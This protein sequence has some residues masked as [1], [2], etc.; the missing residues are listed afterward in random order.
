MEGFFQPAEGMREAGEL[1]RSATRDIFERRGVLSPSRILLRNYPVPHPITA[2]NAGARRAGDSLYVYP[3]IVLGYYK[4]VSSIVEL[5]IPLEDVE[6]GSVS[7][8]S[9]VGNIVI[10]P[11]T[12]YD[13]WG[14]EDPRLYCI[15]GRLYMTYTGRTLSY[16]DP[17][18]EVEK[19]LPVTAVYEDGKWEK[20]L[21]F[22]L[23]PEAGLVSDKDAF[24]CKV[25]GRLY[26]FHRPHLL[27]G[28]FHLVVSMLDKSTL[29]AGGGL[30]EVEVREGFEVLRAA[31]FESKL[32]WAA[33]P[34]QV[35]TESVVVLVHAV[36]SEGVVYRVF[37]V[38]LRLSRSG[39]S[40]E[41]VTPYY[42]M[43]PRA[44]Y[45]VVGDRPYTIFPCGLVEVEDEVLVTYGAGDYVVGF[46]AAKLDDLLASLEEGELF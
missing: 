36:D 12:R 16:F 17:N 31:P 3:R 34:L 33:P 41:A 35:S 26:F 10:S 2:F 27:R 25:G 7:Q 39:V 32:G 30:R 9:Y 6:G 43:E 14:A 44:P 40:V 20:C 15:G 4:Y 13:I 8:N 29:A 19:T 21:I 11:S 37:A 22:K 23:P 24:L 1:R 5:E 45:E 46:A 18:V 42:I 38:R 28:S